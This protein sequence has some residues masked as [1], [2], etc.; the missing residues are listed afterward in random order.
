M[1]GDKNVSR[2]DITLLFHIQQLGDNSQCGQSAIAVRHIADHLRPGAQPAQTAQDAQGRH[3]AA[4]AFSPGARNADLD[5]MGSPSGTR[6]RIRLRVY[7]RI[8]GLQKIDHGSAVHAAV[9]QQFKYINNLFQKHGFPSPPQAFLLVSSSSVNR[10][11]HITG[12]STGMPSSRSSAAAI[13]MVDMP[14]QLRAITSAP[15]FFCI[16]AFFAVAA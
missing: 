7:L 1:G 4:R 16:C 10:P 14:V 6:Q 12:S 11:S 13:L 15:I 9:I 5:H 8:N 3:S 2:Q